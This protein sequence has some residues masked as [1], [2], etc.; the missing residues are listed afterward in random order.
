MNERLL[1]C[2]ILMFSE[3]LAAQEVGLVPQ[4][5]PVVLLVDASQG[6]Y[7]NLADKIVHVFRTS[8]PNAN[9]RLQIAR[10]DFEPSAAGNTLMN[11]GENLPALELPPRT[12]LREALSACIERLSS[13]E[14]HGM[15][16]ILAHEE[17]YQS[18]ISSRRLEDSAQSAEITV[19]SIHFKSRPKSDRP[20][21][22]GRIGRAL[23]SSVIWFMDRFSNEPGASHG[24]TADLLKGLAE[25]T[26]GSTCEANDE[27]TGLACAEHILSLH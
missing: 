11:Q 2:A 19:H 13:A 22:F 7:S 18:W 4:Q 3:G 5:P 25:R 17:S 14:T 9:A 8:S 15:L 26:G 27:Q 10:F 12:P 20:G 6:W 23:G 1:C 16:V 24:E 21:F